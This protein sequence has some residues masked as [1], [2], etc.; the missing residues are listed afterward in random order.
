MMAPKQRQG[1]PIMKSEMNSVTLRAGAEEVANL[2][3]TRLGG[4]RRGEAYDLDTM[5]RRRGGALPPKLLKQAQLLNRAYISTGSPKIARQMDYAQATQ[6]H[7][8]LVA[9]LKP[10]G[11]LSRWQERSTNLVASIVFGLLI[12]AV[13]VLWLLVWRGYL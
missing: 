11:R 13:V 6:A 7:E 9:Y 2:I 3:A 1:C 10:Y 5:I 4:V 8:A 12:L